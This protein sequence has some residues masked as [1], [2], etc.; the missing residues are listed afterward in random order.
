VSVG[1]T[2]TNIRTYLVQNKDCWGVNHEC[3]QAYMLSR[4]HLSSNLKVETHDAVY[5][6]WQVIPFR[7]ILVARW[8]YS[9][10]KSLLIPYAPLKLQT[11]I[12]S[13]TSTSCASWFLGRT[14]IAI[15]SRLSVR[16]HRRCLLHMICGA[17][18]IAI[19]GIRVAFDIT[20]KSQL[21]WTCRPRI[22]MT[23]QRT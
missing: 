4:D 10:R 6:P 7:Y 3:S 22:D 1:G 12:Y 9:I 23:V 15:N 16:P 13:F 8:L 17:Y 14:L 19:Q 20:K 18:S 11:R 5:L 21:S 2:S